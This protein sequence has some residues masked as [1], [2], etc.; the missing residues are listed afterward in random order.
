MAAPER[1]PPSF[2]EDHKSYTTQHHRR[3]GIPFIQ[4]QLYYYKPLLAH[5]S[6]RVGT[7]AKYSHPFI[8]N[9]GLHIHTRPSS[10]YQ[11]YRTAYSHKTLLY[12]HEPFYTG[13]QVAGKCLSSSSCFVVWFGCS[14][15]TYTCKLL[16]SFPP[17]KCPHK[18]ISDSLSFPLCALALHSSNG[19]D[20][21]QSNGITNT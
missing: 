18:A 3:E 8:S 11:Q 19:I 9:T 4:Q 7:M 12:D 13:K 10:T 14:I 5:V 16:D 6:R 1:K 15:P 17:K 2:Q 20:C 21:D